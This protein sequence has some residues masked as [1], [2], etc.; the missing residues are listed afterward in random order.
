MPWYAAHQLLESKAFAVSPTQG[1]RLDLY[2]RKLTN[3]RFSEKSLTG[4]RLYTLMGTDVTTTS[5]RDDGETEGAEREQPEQG[6]TQHEEQHKSANN[7]VEETE[8]NDFLWDV[9]LK[10]MR[11][12]NKHSQQHEPRSGSQWTQILEDLADAT[13]NEVEALVNEKTT[14]RVDIPLRHKNYFVVR[15]WF[16]GAEDIRSLQD[17]KAFEWRQAEI[18]AEN[19]Y[20]AARWRDLVRLPLAAKGH[21][22]SR[23]LPPVLEDRKNDWRGFIAVLEDT[24]IIGKSGV[25]SPSPSRSEV[26][27]PEWRSSEWWFL[28]ERVHELESEMNRRRE[29]AKTHARKMV[30]IQRRATS[31]AVAA[32]SPS[33]VSKPMPSPS[34][35]STTTASLLRKES[36]E[37]RDE[38]L[39]LSYLKFPMP[40][41]V[42]QGA[43]SKHMPG[44]ADLVEQVSR[45]HPVNI[46]IEPAD[47]HHLRIR[48]AKSFHLAGGTDSSSYILNCARDVIAVASIQKTR[49]VTRHEEYANAYGRKI[50]VLKE[51]TDV[52]L[53]PNND[54]YRF[55]M[56][57]PGHHVAGG[58][59]NNDFL[60][61]GSQPV[62]YRGKLNKEMQ[63]HGYGVL[64][65]GDAGFFVGFFKDGWRSGVGAIITESFASVGKWV[66]P[67]NQSKSLRVGWH[68]IFEKD[69]QGVFTP[70]GL[71]SY[72]GQH[73][74]SNREVELVIQRNLH[75][76]TTSATAAAAAAGG[77]LDT[78][79]S[80]VV[81]R[82][83]RSKQK[84]EEKKRLRHLLLAQQ[85]EELDHVQQ[86]RFK[87]PGETRRGGVVSS[88]DK[89]SDEPSEDSN[90]YPSFKFALTAPWPGTISEV[91]LS[92]RYARGQ[93]SDEYFVREAVFEKKS[94]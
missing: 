5:A 50:K 33:S 92:C 86:G 85:D 55:I 27:D 35:A 65:I 28:A 17:E 4:D 15:S 40:V 38:L 88:A 41:F 19:A 57:N 61:L 47:I 58:E 60:L 75:H 89:R 16:Q 72:D 2:R 77:R 26:A 59:I 74:W 71:W 91:A 68:V 24:G 80:T 79:T 11:N 52:L 54:A 10:E 70:K 69:T 93:G 13:K 21:D 30:E 81:E 12:N 94:I 31:T 25:G 73:L 22:L 51:K 82:T 3:F 20:L 45:D 83:S 34:P 67:K 78:T 29:E 7:Y 46:N 62:R 53:K 84:V 6:A 43:H 8:L 18:D 64:Q 90:D 87:S 39:R 9:D 76:Q 49:A 23:L 37:I 32:S 36:A 44:A 48:L 66:R 63:P 1:I 14:I 42:L 56:R